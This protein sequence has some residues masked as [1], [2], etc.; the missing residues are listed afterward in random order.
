MDLSLQMDYHSRWTTAQLDYCP[1]VSRLVSFPLSQR[2]IILN[3]KFL[4]VC[5]DLQDNEDVHSQLH[6]A[7]HHKLEGLCLSQQFIPPR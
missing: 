3:F 2:I 4:A 6:C 5:D 1:I 7:T